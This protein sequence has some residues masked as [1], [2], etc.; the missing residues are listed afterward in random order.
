[1]TN[2]AGVSGAQLRQ[3]IEQVEYL[4]EQK[5]ALAGDM[6][7]VFTEAKN[8]GFDTK[9]MREILKIRKMDSDER[10]ERE[11]ILDVYLQALERTSAVAK[12]TGEV[13]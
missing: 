1:M 3:Y 11:E 8:A 5:A 6:R 10:R 12:N 7:D 9:I 13:A 2:Y 4:E